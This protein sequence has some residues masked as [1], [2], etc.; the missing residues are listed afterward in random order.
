MTINVALVTSDA[1]ILG[2]DSTASRGSY[3]IDPF[4]IGLDGQGATDALL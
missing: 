2:C 4:E 1:L 3:Y